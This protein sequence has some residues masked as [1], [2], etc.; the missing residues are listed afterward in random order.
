[1]EVSFVAA[2]ATKFCATIDWQIG[3]GSHPFVNL[4]SFVV[5]QQTIAGAECFHCA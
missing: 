5:A 2:C 4:Q 3:F 1:M